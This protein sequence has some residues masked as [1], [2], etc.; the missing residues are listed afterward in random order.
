LYKYNDFKENYSLTIVS[1]NLFNTRNTGQNK[2]EKNVFKKSLNE[3]FKVS[4]P[5]KNRTAP[6][7]YINPI[8]KPSVKSI[9]LLFIYL[10]VFDYLFNLF[11]C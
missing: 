3:I 4:C 5:E 6:K 7:I 11:Q 2:N 1:Y 9:I 8:K 10:F